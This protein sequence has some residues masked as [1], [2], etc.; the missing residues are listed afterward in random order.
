MILGLILGLAG[1]AV[2]AVIFYSLVE[3]AVWSGVG[4][5]LR[6]HDEWQRAGDGDA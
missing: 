2:G 3:H 1:A 5:A 4:R 6:D